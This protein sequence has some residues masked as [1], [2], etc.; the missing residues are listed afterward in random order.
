MEQQAQD[1][2]LRPAEAMALARLSK[3]ELWRRVA[4]GTFPK[5]AQLSD[6]IFRFSKVE[7][8]AWVREQFAARDKGLDRKRV[9][10]RRRERAKAEATA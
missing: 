4:E 5:P 9:E 3:S 8:L 1:E 7:V 10:E 6:R 2:P